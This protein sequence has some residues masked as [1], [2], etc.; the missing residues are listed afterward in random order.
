MK[1]LK[2][3]PFFVSD[4]LGVI[5]MKEY[6][7]LFKSPELQTSYEMNFSTLTST[8]VF[9]VVLAL[10]SGYRQRILN[11]DERTATHSSRTDG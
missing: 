4:V 1:S 9:L 10:S 7:S 11:S 8:P 3:L 2:V 6:F 5:A